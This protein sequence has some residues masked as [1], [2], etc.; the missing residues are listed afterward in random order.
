MM[1]LE[2][3]IS[4][5]NVLGEIKFAPVLDILDVLVAAASSVRNF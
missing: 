1:D 5:R 4:R 2:E 3:S